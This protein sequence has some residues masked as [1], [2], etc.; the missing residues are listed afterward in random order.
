VAIQKR[1]VRR[2]RI[3]LWVIAG[4]KIGVPYQIRS[5]Q[6]DIQA[7]M[8]VKNPMDKPLIRKCFRNGEIN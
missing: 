5:I 7:K 2:F 4:Y 1:K 3:R 8:T 6:N